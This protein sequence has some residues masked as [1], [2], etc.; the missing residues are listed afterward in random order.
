MPDNARA[1]FLGSISFRWKWF[2][3]LD[4]YLKMTFNLQ[5]GK[6]NTIELCR[7]FMISNDF[8]PR[9]GKRGANSFFSTM[10]IN[11]C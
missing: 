1:G 8:L 11:S 6:V 5:Y 7:R 2:T 3:I 10:Q 9:N 4:G